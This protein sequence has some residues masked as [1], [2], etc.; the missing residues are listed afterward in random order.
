MEADS[1]ARRMG[2]HCR[3][4][5]L[6]RIRQKALVGRQTRNR[7]RGIE[8]ACRQQGCARASQS[9]RV[10][11]AGASASRARDRECGSSAGVCGRESVN[12]RVV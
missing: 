5:E 12:A 7:G 8:G 9:T 10:S 3:Q 11:S 2:G 4:R 1:R 6:A